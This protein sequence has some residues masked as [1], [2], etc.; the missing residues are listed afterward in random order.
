MRP[1]RL[2]GKDLKADMTVYGYVGARQVVTQ[3]KLQPGAHRAEEASTLVLERWAC[4]EGA[5][6]DA[7]THTHA[8]GPNAGCRQR[9]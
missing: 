3:Q 8:L 4:M 9:R 6:V 5:F 2:P 1:R 7:P